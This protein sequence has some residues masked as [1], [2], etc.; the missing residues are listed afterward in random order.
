MMFIKS[1]FKLETFTESSIER[2]A[3]SRTPS[4]VEVSESEREVKLKCNMLLFFRL[5]LPPYST[6][7]DLELLQMQQTKAFISFHAFYCAFVK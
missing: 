2:L 1:K 7:A 4:V 3:P 6:S 5:P